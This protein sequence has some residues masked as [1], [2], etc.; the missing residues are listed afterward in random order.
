MITE[1]HPSQNTDAVLNN[2]NISNRI[3]RHKATT[4]IIGW[5]TASPT[6]PHLMNQHGRSDTCVLC[7]HWE[8]C[9]A[10]PR[11][12][13]SWPIF[14]G[15][16]GNPIWRAA[17]FVRGCLSAPHQ[18]SAISTKPTPRSINFIARSIW[19][20]FFSE[21]DLP[22]GSMEDEGFSH[23][24]FR[25]PSTSS[26]L[27]APLPPLS[28]FIQANRAVVNQLPYLHSRHQNLSNREHL[29]LNSLAS[30]RRFIIKPADK[31]SGIVIM[32]TC[33][34]A[35]RID[36]VTEFEEQLWIKINTSP[37]HDI[38]VGTKYRSPSS[39]DVNNVKLCDLLREVT[40][41]KHEHLVITGDFNLKQLDWA[42]RELSGEYSSYQYK[43][44]DTI[45]DLFLSENVKQPTRFRGS[46]T[47]SNLDWVLSENASC[48]SE[49]IID[50]P[51]GPSD[52]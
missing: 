28:A 51:L 12:L 15:V 21:N 19:L 16:A 40:K 20:I 14:F 9:S 5:W 23:R 46:D 43:V 33:D 8:G 7:W 24:N 36:R 3:L 4:T 6:G 13:N 44:F 25:P 1:T 49:V 47:P 22:S 29:A 38:L 48:V 41:I 52:K 50:A 32:N 42:K 11:G 17:Y 27:E 30:N 18:V 31:G 35:Y 26:P 39:P 34:Y 37:K 45:N 2:S 10:Y